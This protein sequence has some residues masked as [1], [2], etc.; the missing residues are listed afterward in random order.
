LTTR[1]HEDDPE[2]IYI[3]PQ[4]FFSTDVRNHN[5]STNLPST[6]SHIRFPTRTAFLD[7]LIDTLLDPPIGFRHWKLT[8]IM[9]VYIGYL[10]TYTLRAYP[11]VLPSGKLE[12]EH[13]SVLLSLK[14]ENRHYFDGRI[15]RTSS[16]WLSDVQER[17]SFLE[18][19]GRLSKE[20]R[21][22]PR[23]TPERPVRSEIPRISAQVVSR[24][25]AI[26][27]AQRSPSQSA[28]AILLRLQ[29]WARRIL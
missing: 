2:T 18:R 4:S 14:V 29:I 1:Q 24:Y 19:A 28:Q 10:I 25:S 5:L 3:H 13:E 16:G 12:P 9:E 15:R 8:Q 21:P 26:P 11:R 20:S 27:R 22:L 17:R 7:S 6:H 23:N